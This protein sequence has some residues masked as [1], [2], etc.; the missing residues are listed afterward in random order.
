M[1]STTKPWASVHAIQQIV[2]PVHRAK[3]C[4]K[5]H[6]LSMDTLARYQLTS[7][8]TKPHL[9]V[10]F[11]IPHQ[12]IPMVSTALIYW[13]GGDANTDKNELTK[14]PLF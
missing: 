3:Q 14:C 11:H 4:L 5:W 8:E 10:L 1:S 6:L 2:P 13:V 12:I 9:L 7:A